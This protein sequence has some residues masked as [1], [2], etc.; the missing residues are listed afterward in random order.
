M[1]LLIKHNICLQ[2]IENEQSNHNHCT[3]PYYYKQRNPEFRRLPLTDVARGTQFNDTEG[4]YYK[5]QCKLK[6]AD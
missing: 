1:I 3:T 4:L 2:Q 6:V 5:F